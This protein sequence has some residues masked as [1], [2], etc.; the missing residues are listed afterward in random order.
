MSDDNKDKD[1][2]GKV[3]ALS[4]ESAGYRVQ[5][6]DALKREHLLKAVLSKHGVDTEKLKDYDLGKLTVNDG[7]VSG[8]VNYEVPAPAKVKA[9]SSTKAVNVKAE[10]PLTLKEV[11]DN[12][13]AEQINKN[14]SK[15]KTL[16]EKEA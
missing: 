16:M 8:E 6:N 12:W 10:P 2:E 5:R 3:Q 4:K 15:V 9:G 7:V 14:W 1:L 11:E 13:S